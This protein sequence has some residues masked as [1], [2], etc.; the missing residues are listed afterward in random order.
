MRLARITAGDLVRDTDGRLAEVT[1][2]V[3]GRELIVRYV[4]GATT[5]RHLKGRQVTA[6]YRKVG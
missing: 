5:M 2:K 4:N 1:D 3:N 6:H